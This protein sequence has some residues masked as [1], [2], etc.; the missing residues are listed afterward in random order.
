MQM[1]HSDPATASHSYVKITVKT[2][3]LKP[4]CLDLYTRTK[5]K[6]GGLCRSTVV[7]HVRQANPR[8]KPPAHI[9]SSRAARQNKLA[10]AEKSGHCGFVSGLR[11]LRWVAGL[12]V[13]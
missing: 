8:Y 3:P 13:P 5:D 10:A 11:P 4:G 9:S 2:S 6:D 1:T 12:A 7:V